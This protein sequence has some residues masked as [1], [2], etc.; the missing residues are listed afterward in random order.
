MT[1]AV[2]PTEAQLRGAL[3][4]LGMRPPFAQV[5]AHRLALDLEASGFLD[6]LAREARTDRMREL[7][8]HCA[9]AALAG[10]WAASSEPPTAPTESDLEWIC[11]EAR[12]PTTNLTSDDLL[13][14]AAGY[15]SRVKGGASCPA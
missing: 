2:P 9:T 6:L 13:A 4:V 8:R 5:Y 11:A 14:I 10:A 12:V 1:P 7:G 15:R 3:E